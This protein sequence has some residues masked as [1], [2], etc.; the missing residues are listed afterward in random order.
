MRYIRKPM[1][2]IRFILSISLFV[3]GIGGYALPQQPA[4]NAPAYRN[5]M[6]VPASVSFASGRLVVGY[7]FSAAAKGYQDARLLAGIQRASRRIELRTGLEFKPV[8]A[9]PATATLVVECKTAGKTIPALD[10]DESYSLDVTDK[11]ASLKANTVVG[12]LRGLETFLQLI[13][14]DQNGYFVPSVNI[15]DKPRFAWRGLLIDSCRHFQPIEVIKRELDGMAAVKL[16]VLH[17]HLTEDQ[18]FRVEVRKY[19]K[20]HQMGSDGLYYTQDQIRDVIAYA[21]ERGIRVVPEFDMPGHA[22]SWLVGYPELGSAPGPYQIIRR[23]GIFDA[24]LDPTRDEVYKFIDGFLGE[25]AGLFPDAYMHIGG[26]ESNGK[27][28]KQ[29]PKIQAFMKEKNIKDTEALQSYFTVKVQ[30]IVAKHKK[31]MIG[32]D[33][34]YSP[35]MPK[36]IVIHSWRGAES[37]AKGASNGY[38]G[39][40]S[41]GYY[42]DHMRP[43]SFHYAV[44]PIPAN[45]TLTEQQKELILGGEACMWSEYV[46]P[47]TIDS[48]IWPR[49]GAIAERL[50]SPSS[51]TDVDDMYRRTA[52][53]SIQLEVFGL[54]NETTTDRLMR[55]LAG[56]S[57]IGSL[58]SLVE[59]VEPLQGYNRGKA[60]PSTQMTPLTRMVDA[61]K[62]ESATGRWFA[63]SVD[64][65]LMDAPNFRRHR[66]DMTASLN[67][68]RDV[69]TALVPMFERSPVLREAEP[70]AKDLAQMSQAGLDAISHLSSSSPATPE[71]RDST[72]AMLAE[73][74]KHDQAA[75]GLSIITSV[76]QLVIA[77]AELDQLKTSTPAEWS[78]RVKTMANEKPKNGRR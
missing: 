27:Q 76:K 60:H 67:R 1:K 36:N 48:R 62:P 73:A 44:D 13:E 78:K 74:A 50:W 49:L 17:W 56:S 6:P 39:I 75:V 64:E 10:E 66:E 63:K 15:Q 14:G 57:D 58:K 65:F 77:A 71:W 5:L 4:M 55:N 18:G 40:L 42:L 52:A 41:S 35:E 32:W 9:D 31:R 53:L 37:L 47:D 38:A 11:Q 3:G 46:S 51:I 33:E 28:W 20:L 29:N 2:I 24:A 45:S 70:L 16:N 54:N 22:T 25:M 7:E 12:A 43:A 8:P 23:W 59:L 21:T 68:W 61:A 72:L 26:D 34:I 30:T 19:P 69:N